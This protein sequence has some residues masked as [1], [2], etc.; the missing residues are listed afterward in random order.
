[1]VSVS[2]YHGSRRYCDGNPVLTTMHGDMQ[3]GPLPTSSSSSSLHPADAAISL[4]D[5]KP[6]EDIIHSYRHE[7]F[8]SDSNATLHGQRRTRW[9]RIRNSAALKHPQSYAKLSRFLRYWRGPRP[10]VDLSGFLPSLISHFVCS[11]RFA[12]AHPHSRHRAE[13]SEMAPRSSY[14]DNR[15]E[16]NQAADEGLDSSAS[17]CSLYY[18]ICLLLA[19]TIIPHPLFLVHRMYCGLLGLQ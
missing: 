6:S 19:R 2:N 16:I 8:A 4:H 12:R 1:M 3:V 17:W 5:R 14:G 7:G 13:F 18:R 10:K 11:Y 15:N 9:D